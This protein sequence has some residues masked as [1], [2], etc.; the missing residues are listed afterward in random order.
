MK[1]EPGQTWSLI[2]DEG[3][4]TIATVLELV[5]EDI[6]RVLVLSSDIAD[7]VPG[8]LDNFS[9]SWFWENSTL[10]SQT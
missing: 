9:V 10:L 8:S 7:C 2:D 3:G 4:E 5:D 6:V 1:V